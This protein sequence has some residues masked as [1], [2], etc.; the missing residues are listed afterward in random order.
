LSF[1]LWGPLP[2][3]LMSAFGYLGHQLSA[4]YFFGL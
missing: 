2:L 4:S 3:P 1:N